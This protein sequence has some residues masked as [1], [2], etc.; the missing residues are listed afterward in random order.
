MA[1]IVLYLQ[2]TRAYLVLEECLR[3]QPSNVVVRLLAAKL[4]YENLHMV[5]TLMI[6]PSW[7]FPECLS[8]LS[9]VCGRHPAFGAGC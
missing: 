1:E 5:G 8:P 6:N 2:F 9:L 4:C 3:L 7:A